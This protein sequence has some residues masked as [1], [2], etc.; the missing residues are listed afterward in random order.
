MSVEKNSVVVDPGLWAATRSGARAGRGFRFQDVATAL[1]AVEAWAGADWQAVVP[2]GVDDATLHGPTTEIRVQ[3]KSRHDPRGLFKPS[4]IGAHIAHS[5]KDI[6][7][8]DLRS[9][10]V[11]LLLL[12]ERPIDG[13]GATGR[14]T[15]L[16]GEPDVMEALRAALRC[17]AADLDVGTDDILAATRVR[18]VSDP[19]D[20]ITRKVADRTGCVEAAGRLAADRLQRIIGSLAD[21]NYRAPAAAPASF[22]PGDVQLVIDDVLRV[23]DRVA[24]NAAVA[25]GLVEP[26]SF[27]P[28]ETLGFYDGVDVTPGH[29]GAGLVLDRPELVAEVSEGLQRRNAALIV[30]P[31]GIGKSACAWL[32]AHASRHAIRWYRVRRVTPEQVHILIGLARAVEAS[33]ERPVGFVLDDLGRDLAGGWDALRQEA[34]TLPGVLLLGTVREEDL[35]LV[36]NL[37]PMALVRPLLNEELAERIWTALRSDR[38][39]AYVNWREPFELSRGLTLEYVHLLTSGQRLQ[40]TLDNQVRRRLR[41]GR[42]DELAVMHAV[43]AV[44]RLGGSVDRTR[45]RSRLG[46]TEGAFARALARLVDEHAIRIA[47]DGSLTGLHEIRSIGLYDA[48]GRMMARNV[49]EALDELIDVLNPATVATVLPRLLANGEVDAPVLLD[50]LAVRALEWSTPALAATFYGLGLVTCERI[51]EQWLTI[52]EEEGVETRFAGLTTSL[53]IAGSVMNIPQLARIDASIARRGEL[54]RPDLRAELLARLGKLDRLQ[55]SLSEYHDLVSSL[56][57][58]PFLSAIPGLDLLP[59]VD[60]VGIDLDQITDVLST[61]SAFG[62]ARAQRVV[63]RFGGTEM[64]LER[65]HLEKAWTT[66]PVLRQEEDGL[67]AASDIRYVDAATQA[68]TNA[69]VVAHC[70]RL[71]AVAPTAGFAACTLIGWDGR[72]AGFGDFMVASKRLPRSAAPPAVTIAWNRALLRAVQRR[73]AATTES[74]RANAL[75]SAIKELADMLADAAELQCRGTKAA[76]RAETMLTIRTLLNSFIQAPSVDLAASTPRDAG[77]GELSDGMRDFVISVTDLARELGAGQIERPLLKAAE[78]ARLRV[79]AIDLRDASDWRWLDAAPVEALDRIEVTLADI[80]AMLGLAHGDPDFCRHARLRAERS[81]RHNRALP[82]FATEARARAEVRGGKL[83][84]EIATALAEDGRRPAMAMRPAADDALFWPRTEFLALIEVSHFL[85]FA[86]RG[87]EMVN[88]GRSAADDHPL[89]LVP[90]REGYVVAMGAGMIGSIFLP[91]TTFAERWGPYLPMPMIEERSAAILGEAISSA[92]QISAALA[93]A[94]RLPNVEEEAYVQSL[95]DGLRKSIADL[96]RLR[97]NEPDEDTEMASSFVLGIL[98]RLQAEAEEGFE[99]ESMASEIAR[100][101]HGEHTDFSLHAQAYRIGLIE[102]DVLA[103]VATKDNRARS[104]YHEAGD[105]VCST[106]V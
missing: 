30:G 29:V 16:S 28:V 100:L 25:A 48:L 12:L 57:P 53:A 66:R 4:E 5:A 32:T 3:V 19:A 79:T 39:L 60:P 1:L 75:A 35:H 86:E 65:I 92:V 15:A 90:V 68:D 17:V 47:S 2:E 89:Y 82:R 70:D 11:R 104:D 24:I 49:S 77:S 6:T 78:S 61:M 7:A 99:G 56:A 50:A 93:N 46:L 101:G 97:D 91:D 59:E 31:S 21:A 43:V 103:A 71:L 9:G 13:I 98:D 81:S 102:R 20:A 42:D 26:V 44:A 22:G 105:V 33:P 69:V 96:T 106:G 18:V 63:D 45:L 83:A 88:A 58:L 27:A 84:E 80:D 40:D 62:S 36:T 52:L 64:L 14:E 8:T 37:A 10:R 85:R 23:V 76:P 41:E 38:T 73:N 95:V 67:I 72:P 94:D 51:A 34:G 54:D 74:G 87:E 55:P